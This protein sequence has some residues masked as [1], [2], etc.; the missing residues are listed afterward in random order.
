MNIGIYGNSILVDNRKQ[1]FSFITRLKRHY[2]NHTFNNF[3]CSHSSEERMLF[4]IKKTKQLDLAIIFHANPSY[5]FIPGWNR[6]VDTFDKDVL[7]QKIRED[8]DKQVILYLI[9]EYGLKANIAENAAWKE[10]AIRFWKKLPNGAVL[11][12]LEDFS[13]VASNVVNEWGDVS[14]SKDELT[15]LKN[16][17]KQHSTPEDSS[18]Y[19]ELLECL[20]QNKKYMFHPDLQR[21]R[22]TSALIQIDQYLTSKKIPA[23]HC[24]G[25][26]HWYPAWFNFSSG[27]VTSKFTFIRQNFFSEYAESDNGITPEGNEQIFN[28]L[29]TLIDHFYQNTGVSD[30]S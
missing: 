23:I 6:D 25:P 29:L 5:M 2:T 26:T 22:Y 20:L 24:L 18:F 27:K 13:Q 7:E 4:E 19:L 30:Y 9:S 28:E 17:V 15:I 12:L 8:F 16:F 14:S 21:S 1:E 3:G 11:A 10:Q